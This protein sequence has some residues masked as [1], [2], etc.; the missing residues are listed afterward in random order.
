MKKKLAVI[1]AIVIVISAIALTGFAKGNLPTAEKP[2]NP[3][4]A[5]NKTTASASVSL[6]EAIDIALKD[7]GINRED[8]LFRAT[9]SLDSDD[10]VK[11]YDIEFI[12]NGV[13]YEYE[14][15]V[16]E[17]KIINAEKEQEKTSAPAQENV[18]ERER[19]NEKEVKKVQE[20]TSAPKKQ[21]K[22]YISIEQAKEIA[23]K[24]AGKKAADAE[25]RKA[26]YDADDLVAHFDIKFVAD[27]YEYEYEIKAADGKVLEKDIDRVEKNSVPT[28][29]PD[30]APSES[31][32]AKDKALS[33]ALAHAKVDSAQVKYSKVE[34]D[35]DDLIVHYEVE[36]VAGA[37]EY[38]YEINA[39]SGKIVAFDKDFN[40]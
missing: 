24:D 17:G 5:E 26:H 16:E 31:Y 34:L 38:E 33:L 18:K 12:N 13:E 6:D 14:I 7:A 3:P 35:R 4:V 2:T 25:F 21:E 11:H 32:I 37:Y 8:A 19:E 10:R 27:G 15:S 39:E 28:A 29:A 22:A 1:S 23:L 9:P 36:F 20:P 40:D 30:K